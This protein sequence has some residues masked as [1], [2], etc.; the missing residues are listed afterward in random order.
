MSLKYRIAVVIVNY[1]TAA[2]T[3]SC[4]DT[5]LG[6]LDPGRDHI[7]VADNCSGAEDVT[8][9]REAF[10]Q[11][12]YSGWITLVEVDSNRGFSAGNNAALEVLEAEYYLLTNSDTEFRPGAIE[13]LLEGASRNPAAGIISPRLIWPDGTAQVSCFRFHRPATELIRAASTG[14]ITALLRPFVVPLPPSTNISTPEW[15]SFACV[16]ITGDALR[17]VGLLDDGFFMYFED[18]DYCRRIRRAGYDIVNWPSAQV[19]HLQGKSSD[20]NRLSEEKKQL[21]DYYYYARSRY[22]RKYYKL[23]GLL[24]ANFF[25]L[26]G[27]LISVSRGLLQRTARPVPHKESRGIWLIKQKKPLW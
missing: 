3:L 23:A 10:A 7:V 12:K 4:I 22:Y 18:V 13:E 27:R 6:E 9:L 20:V 8:C 5:L 19:V 15:T 21:P 26:T 24:L 2:L 14:V 16:L 25:W 11:A 1:K 17:R